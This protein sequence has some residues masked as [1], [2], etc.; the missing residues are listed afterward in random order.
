MQGIEW[1]EVKRNPTYMQAGPEG[2][3]KIQE[4]WWNRNVKTHPRAAELT[5]EKEALLRTRIF[6]QAPQP[7][8]PDEGGGFLDDMGHTL[9]ASIAR[10]G[11]LAGRALDVLGADETGQA[12]ERRFKTME[13]RQRAEISPLQQREMAK[14]F[15]SDKEGEFFGDAWS[16]PRKLMGT[17]VESAPA[18]VI[19]MGGGMGLAAGLMRLGMSA[20]IAGMVGGAIGE[21]G[22]A[23]AEGSKNV[24]DTVMNAPIKEIARTPEYRAAIA[25]T[26]R[27]MTPKARHMAAVKAIASDAAAR[28]GAVIGLATGALGAPSGAAMGKIIGGEAGKTLLRTMGKQAGLE[29]LQEAPQSAVEQYQQNLVEKRFVDPNLD[30]M[31]GVAEAA[32]AGAVTG[33]AMGAGMGGGA[34]VLTGGVNAGADVT[35]TGGAETGGAEEAAPAPKGPSKFELAARYRSALLPLK[36]QLLDGDRLE[37]EDIVKAMPSIAAVDEAFDGDTTVDRYARLYAR[38]L[39]TDPQLDGGGFFSKKAPADEVAPV[40][41]EESGGGVDS[42][43][44]PAPAPV[45]EIVPAQ[46]GGAGKAYTPTNTP[47]DFEYAVVD[48][49]D[50]RTSHDDDLRESADY[51]AE[52]QPRDRSRKGMIV[53]VNQMANGLIPEKLGASSDVGTGAPV[54]GDDLLV[55]SGNGRT[56]ALRTA[57]KTGKGEAY[58]NWLAEN[59]DQFGV[60]PE[61]VATMDRPMLVRV[62]KDRTG[63]RQF[64][65]EANQ[66]EVA[67]M[68]A[69][70]TAAADADRLTYDDMDLLSADAAGNLGHSENRTFV[71]RFLEKIGAGESAALLDAQGNLTRQGYD[72]LRAAVFRK[73]YNNDA[74]TTLQAEAAAGDESIRNI[75]NAM[76]VAAPEFAKARAAAPDLGGLD[77]TGSI[78]EAALLI[79]QA[80]AEGK[81][82]DMLL[83]QRGMFEQRA[84][85]TE[86]MARFM[87]QNIRSAKRMGLALSKAAELIRRDLMNRNQMDLFGDRVAATPESVTQG[88]IDYAD[89]LDGGPGAGDSVRE[90]SGDTGREAARNAVE[91]A[92]DRG[93]AGIGEREITAA[94]TGRRVA[95]NADGSYRVDFGGKPLTIRSVNH[96]GID[97]A[98]F[99][100]SY[101]RALPESARQLG[102]AGAYTT[103]EIRISRQGDKFTLSH[104]LYHALRDGGMLTRA[105]VRAVEKAAGSALEEDQAAWIERAMADREAFREQGILYS[106]I[107]K[108]GDLWDGLVN[109]FAET[110]RGVVRGMESGEFYGRENASGP[111][112]EITPGPPL[113][114]GGER[115][116]VPNPQTETAAF[117][118]WF[119]D[120]KVVD[121]AGRP[122]VVYHGTNAV[123][124]SG[125]GVVGGDA[126]A[127]E[128]LTEIGRAIGVKEWSSVAGV[129]NRMVKYGQGEQYGITPETAEEVNRLK[130]IAKGDVTGGGEE[131]GFHVFKFPK[132]NELGV[133]L[134]NEGAAENRGTPFPMYIRMDRPLRL[135]DLGD[136]RAPVVI[137][138]LRGAGI[139]VSESEQR[140]VLRAKNPAAALRELIKRKGYDGVVYANEAEGYG[141]SYIV[142]DPSQIKSATGNTGAF[143]PK[144][145][146]IRYSVPDVIKDNFQVREDIGPV[147]AAREAVTDT[148]QRVKDNWKTWA[149]DR[150]NPVKAL[151]EMPYKLHRLA[152]G[153]RATLEA[154]LEHGPIRWAADG[155]PT[156]E[157]VD[158]GFLPWIREIGPDAQKLFYWMA[159]KRAER[160]EG[161]GREKWL[162]KT[163][164]NEILNWVGAKPESAATWEDLNVKFQEYNQSVLDFAEQSGLLKKGAW[165]QEDIYIPFYRIFEDAN[166]REEFL[167]GPTSGKK[168]L[169]AGI[170][171]LKGS[172]AKIG[173][174]L[175]NILRNWTHL[176]TESITNNARAEAFESA[177]GLGLVKEIKVH[178]ILGFSKSKNGQL[179]YVTRKNDE[180]VLSFNDKGQR[181]YFRVEDPELYNALADFHPKGI[182]N[183]IGRLFSASKRVLTRGATFGPAFRMSNMI[184]DS[185]HTAIVARNF[186][187]M[188]D[189]MRGFAKA[190][191]QDADYVRLMASGAGF[192]SDYMK[193]DD[194]AALAKY[195]DQIVNK[196]GAGAKE[197]ILSTPRK[198]LAFWDRLGEA[199]EQAARVALYQKRMAAGAS[200]LD[201]AYEA[202]DLL[203]FSM[204][205]SAG[206]VRYL[207]QTIPF[208]NARMQGLYRLGRGA[209]ADPKGF[210]VKGGLLA[211]AS[212]GLWAANKDDERYKALED[213]DKWTFYHFW[214]GDQHYRIPKPFEV[215]AIFSTLFESAA[216]ATAGDEDLGY[217]ADALTHTVTE[218]FAV[219]PLPQALRPPVEWWSN[220]SMF[221]GRPIESMADQGRLPGYRGNSRTS[222][223]MRLIGEK[224]NVSPP[225]L[226]GVVRGYFSTIGEAMLIMSDAIVR[227]ASDLPTRPAAEMRDYP[228]LGRFMRG[229]TERTSK[230]MTRFYQMYNE[231]NQLQRT[232]SEAKKSGDV[233]LA[234]ELTEKGAGKLRY[235]TSVNRAKRELAKIYR[236]MRTVENSRTMNAEKK[237]AALNQ[238][239]EKREKIVKGIYEKV[240]AGR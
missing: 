23:G 131:I 77:I 214:V 86:M 234:Q 14:T 28:A 79:R 40:P 78:A 108:I 4:A 134:G 15:L 52:F 92:A 82:V 30:P 141:D 222:A 201:A 174:P 215:G 114:K 157:T 17:I 80:R 6:G 18:T 127:K 31:R 177:K 142:F 126:A 162:D 106:A 42:V 85:E 113:E 54:V 236:K 58:R 115:Y 56:I 166:K 146:D 20:G 237:R 133:H 38:R 132:S 211:L 125:G 69:S 10:T 204:S 212:L 225:K 217:F 188:I 27:N 100:V 202:K 107:Q 3:K 96:I 200:G 180:N 55:E 21:G 184:R 169:D 53:Q 24:Y 193:A 74:L 170:K 120:S 175:E 118:R 209:A 121:D 95:R 152:T 199:S 36:R 90:Q 11:Q 226:E 111:Q 148:V 176:I 151:G 171:E 34:Q 73:A 7:A 84:P 187:P 137:D 29:A 47:V 155:A 139:A 1:D 61:M 179:T 41:R 231:I 91:D 191:R 62:R 221:T 172:E 25:N 32:T 220:K 72:R 33:A 94:F 5:P 207:I 159:A 216:D 26:D 51:P 43:E 164:R 9:G 8:A 97:E 129:V 103:G 124:Y 39:E 228:L 130:A 224:T 197:T 181:R 19:G 117:K 93:G 2:Q 186:M 75:I 76:T 218:T 192:G 99:E 81:S 208:L 59:A 44:T 183:A 240:R 213:W 168:Y 182:D 67:G 87:D 136:W 123:E 150:L 239:G 46:K 154:F 140:D 88:G 190:W 71:G 104:E 227:Q 195:I 16:S 60:N 235:R 163:K 233:A 205:G 165:A 135:P 156:V 13:E 153:S 178:E 230:Y 48:A 57:Y 35:E 83:G 22:Y 66:A 98:V 210:A 229:S 50:L 65:K 109:L 105:E 112:T 158:E 144:N 102:A 143:D 64:V 194:P 101:R 147:Q 196:E 49:G 198:M 149:F 12:I 122:L 232:I 116:A 189:T 45:R 185:L 89:E 173:D 167:K 161:Q 138:A 70:E 203:D 63:R 238:L 206:A 68:S 119:G 110:G 223:T 160:L 128:R 219:N 145:P 37:A